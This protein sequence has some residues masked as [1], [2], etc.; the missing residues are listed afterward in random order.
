MLYH[1]SASLKLTYTDLFIL[2]GEII[3]SF[4]ELK[5]KMHSYRK[6]NDKE[7]KKIKKYKNIYYK[8]QNLV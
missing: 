8:T 1:A 2:S 4:S 5:P 3:R 6:D 7:D